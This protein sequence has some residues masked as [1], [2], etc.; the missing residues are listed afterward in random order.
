MSSESF[1]PVTS[2]GIY[3]SVILP[4]AV[5]KPYTYF[6]PSEMMDLV[7]PGIRVEVQL[8]KKK[9]YSAIVL[10][11]TEKAPEGT[12][13]KPILSII[14]KSPIV[15]AT[16]LKLWKWMAQY[17]CCSLGEVMVAALPAGLKMSSET[18][19][20]MSPFFTEDYT[21]L[22]DK[23]YLVAEALRNRQE[24]TVDDVRQILGQKTV[25]PLL[26][27]LLEKKIIY[28]K[29]E[30][31][32]S[33]KPKKIGCVRLQEPYATEPILLEEAFQLTARSQKQTEALLA[34]VQI[35]KTQPYVRKQDLYKMAAV[36]A[37]VL[38]AMQKKGIFEIYDREIS[39]VGNYAE[40][41][42]EKFD[43]TKIQKDALGQ[44][45]NIFEEKNTVLLHGVTGSGKT[46]IYVEL[47]EEAIKQGEQ[48][49]YLLPEIALTTQ[50]VARL[51]K[52]F[53]DDIAVYH[54]RMNNNERVD[55]WKT[56]LNKKPIILGARSA[57]FLPF[58]NLKLIIVDEEHDP[59]FKQYDPA[60]RYNARDAAIYLAHL[61]SAKVLLGTATPSLETYHNA[62]NE[63]YGLVQITERY[64][65]ME[66]P[67]IIIA[68]VADEIK[69]K[70]MSSHFTSV[71]L[72]ELI[73]A[74]A[75]KEQAIL[76]QNRR[77]YAPTLRCVTC[78]W[79]QEC[80]NCDV[81]LTYH[82]QFENLRCHY[83]GYQQK[84]PKECPA[85]GGFDLTIRGFGTEKIEDEL[86]LYIPEA[87]IAR[88]D[89]D[90][91]RTKNAHARIIQDFEE[92]RIDVLVG[93]QMVTKGLDFD[94]V[95][96]VGVLS[97]DQLMA[98]P[99]FRST[100][101]GFQLM[102]Q[103]S[104]RAG[105]KKKRGKVIIQAFNVAHP[106]LGEVIQNDFQRFF[107]REMEERQLF[108]YPPFLRL[109]KITLK[110]KD[111]RLLNEG[112]KIFAKILKEKLGNRMI[113]PAVPGI[114]R[115]RGSFLLEIFLKMEKDNQWLAYAKNL[116]Q[117]A[118]RSLNATKGF[119]GIRINV[120]VDPI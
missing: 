115:I 104:G 23:E 109:I 6:I 84:I 67:E 35:Y 14:D 42:I 86:K 28:L 51:Q 88:M 119:S 18:Q 5:P 102:T 73:A 40:E 17:Y 69:R 19:I 49:L 116:V 87:K 47:I 62:K 91:V 75:R 10:E 57:L 54:S 31:K 59:S 89:F 65:Q 60:P 111:P 39:R 63:K 61:H 20:V 2:H 114:P 50:I 13:P 120:D 41:T 118:K 66:L 36:D 81:S 93:T 56:V 99:D 72:E 45:K 80:K 100:E 70:K 11:L 33:Y 34:F 27:R 110:H 22:K 64:G 96:V 55:L 68:N 32:G 43:L 7:H 53:G 90:T 76:F 58:R 107:T 79:I 26:Y 21:M 74:L 4:I 25:Y 105:R 29:E 108:S 30:L 15:D 78:G 82:K 1:H 94:N 103:V 97:A 113:G 106:V 85:C 83:C 98:F 112:T 46:R 92:K 95:G 38:N 71:L 9:L 24:L 52:I 44:I 48:V 16:Q 77:G 8:G 101:R 12:K 3:A 117:F 37:A